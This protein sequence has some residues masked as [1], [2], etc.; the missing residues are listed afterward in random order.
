MLRSPDGYRVELLHRVG[1][2]AG[3][4]ASARRGRAD[5]RLRP[6]RPDVADLEAAYDACS[7]PAPPTGCRP[8]RR[9][10]PASGWRTSPTPRATSSSCSTGRRVMTGRLAGKIALITGV[11]GGMGVTA[12][13]MFAPRAPGSWAATS[14]SRRCPHRGSGA[15]RGRRDHRDGR[16]R[17]RRRR[18]RAGLGGRR[19]G[20]VRRH[21]RALQQRLHPAVR[22]AR[23]ADRRGVGL[24]DAQRARPRLLH[25][26]RRLAAPEG[27]T[28]A[29][30]SSTSARSRR[31]AAWSSCRRTRTPPPRAASSR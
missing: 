26:A 18:G 17:P 16:R 11:G 9:P 27:R 25:G 20:D 28:A 4:Q 1:N 10:S 19:R 7:R 15:R 24:H 29:A 31:C 6:R 2:V 8:A 3:L 23:R 14:T 13:S 12:A 5:P 22:R 30:R 21:R